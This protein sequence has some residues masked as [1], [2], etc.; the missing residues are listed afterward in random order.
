MKLFS[1]SIFKTPFVK[2]DTFMNGKLVSSVLFECPH[3]G[4]KGAGASYHIMMENGK[5]VKTWN[6]CINCKKVVTE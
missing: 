4:A 2:T 3:C 6:E 1:I 5:T